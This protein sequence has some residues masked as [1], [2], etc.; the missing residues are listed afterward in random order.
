MV[1]QSFGSE[2]S[3][4]HVYFVQFQILF[5]LASQ[6]WHAFKCLMPSDKKN[7]S[8]SLIYC[9]SHSDI[10]FT[11]FEKWDRL[12]YPFLSKI[13]PLLVFF[14][15]TYKSLRYHWHGLINFVVEFCTFYKGDKFI[16]WKRKQNIYQSL[17]L[18]LSPFQGCQVIP[19]FCSL[20]NN[21]LI[22]PYQSQMQKTCQCFSSYWFKLKC[23]VSH[24]WEE[25]PLNGSH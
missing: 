22:I 24:E 12:F 21:F 18:R 4:K 10:I 20:S 8:T 15:S 17:D 11:E 3:L 6:A 7:N 16:V 5:P 2:C 14:V 9:F 13:L 23:R 1:R 19:R 25:K